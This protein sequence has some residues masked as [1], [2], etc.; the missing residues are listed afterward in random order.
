MG[1]GVLRVALQAHPPGGFGK[2]ALRHYERTR[3]ARMMFESREAFG[4]LRRPRMP[5]N[6]RSGAPRG[7]RPPARGR[8]ELSARGRA[9]LGSAHKGCLASTQR[10]SALRSLFGAREK[11]AKLGEQ[12]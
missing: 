3:G 7:E 1:C 10:L 12:M 2:A 4:S 9:D 6:R 8:R 11:Q 5:I